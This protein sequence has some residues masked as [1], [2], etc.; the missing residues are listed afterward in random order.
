MANRSFNRKQSLEKE[1]KDL[2]LKVSF[3]SSGAPTM[4]GGS[5]Y[6]FASIV[7]NSAGD[8]TITL[9]DK[10]SALKHVSGRFLSSSAQDLNIQLKSEDV[11]S[12]KTIG[13]MMLTGASATDPASGQVLILNVE[14][15]NTSAV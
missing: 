2:Y 15:K 5:S 6:G 8:Y 3:G 1:V 14:L 7:R 12:A 13:L 10:Y 11:V 4:V 9:Q